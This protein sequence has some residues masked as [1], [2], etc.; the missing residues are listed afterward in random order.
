MRTIRFSFERRTVRALLVAA[1][2][3]AAGTLAAQAP[4][5][6]LSWDS[7]SY[8]YDAEG[9]IVS[10]GSDAYGYDAVGRLTTA[11]VKTGHP[12]NRQAYAYD[13]HGN[14]ASVVTTDRYGT[15]T[16][17][18]A[19]DSTTN[20]LTLPAAGCT[21]PGGCVGAD[22][23]YDQA[24]NLIALPREG[25]AYTWDALGALTEISEPMSKRQRYVYDAAGERV[26]TVNVADGMRS[27]AL[28]GA[29]KKVAR[30][31]TRDASGAW[32]W[33]RDYV[34]AGP[35]L[36]AAFVADGNGAGPH[37]HYH[38]DHLDTTRLVTDAAGYEVARYSYWPF[39][40]EASGSDTGATDRL[41]F[42][43]H[44]RDFGY[45]PAWDLDYMHARYAR[46]SWGRFLSVD[47]GRDWDSSK[48]QSWN[49][50]AYVRSNPINVIDPNG[51][52]GVVSQGGTVTV[53]TSHT[54]LS[55]GVARNHDTT[56]NMSITLTIG[57]GFTTSREG[58]NLTGSFTYTNKDRVEDL[59]GTSGSVG[60]A[61]GPYG[62]DVGVDLEKLEPDS[63]TMNIDPVAM[64]VGAKG[65]EA[66]V[67]LQETIEL[68]N[69]RKV[70]EAIA[71]K[72]EELKEPWQFMREIW[73]RS[74]AQK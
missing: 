43:G 26:L 60:G 45:G 22:G 73:D 40:Q 46:P 69:T 21:A 65:V 58:M 59:V 34:H 10:I 44:E 16:V 68:V 37:R 72:L 20:R 55:V 66:Q 27:F 36:I 38:T 15:V 17:G 2:V 29:D 32:R 7:G 62:V 39:G 1:V 24:G 18:F 35:K 54:Y 67:G 14:L 50:Y 56:G 28:R 64:I 52:G 12:D 33:E 9:N 48:P 42:T 57:D 41:R 51:Q 63:V 31:F 8:G 61:G 11:T 49:L 71:K 23:R 47:P 3:L 74:Q 6:S 53:K 19:V 30:E 5:P 25:A 70:M 13:Q 4:D